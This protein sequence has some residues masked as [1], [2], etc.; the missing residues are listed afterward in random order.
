LPAEIRAESVVR[1]MFRLVSQPGIE[2][3][4]T[5]G[6]PK[7]AALLAVSDMASAT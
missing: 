6:T 5:F 4:I 2:N 3:A 7:A 1:D